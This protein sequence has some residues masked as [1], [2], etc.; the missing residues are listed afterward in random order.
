[1]EFP[2]KLENETKI[3]YFAFCDF[4]KIPKESRNL[5]KLSKLI[6]KKRTILKLW[7]QK[8]DWKQ[9]E[10][11]FNNNLNLDD[12]QLQDIE[13]SV[14]SE[15]SKID[16]VEFENI[17]N[18]MVS[19]LLF[20]LKN[21]FYQI[22]DLDI[23]DLGAFIKDLTKSLKDLL[24]HVKDLQ[25]M[26]KDYHERTNLIASLIRKDDIAKDLAFQLL[27]RISKIGKEDEEENE[28]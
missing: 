25:K 20:N 9:R 3:A 26:S 11:Y 15:E 2:Q 22:N 8:Y 27:T 28:D 4:L 10:E 23:L 24:L 7:Y 17:V 16:L 19:N 1:M 6:G 12:K 13:K 18:E 21:K 14:H 5:I